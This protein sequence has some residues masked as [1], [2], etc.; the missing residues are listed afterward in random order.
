MLIIMSGL[1]GTGKSTIAR[2]LARRLNGMFLRADTIAQALISADVMKDDD[3]P[4]AYI[5]GYAVA[6]ENLRT[7]ATV[8][9][10]YV[11]GMELTRQAWRDVA[12]RTNV[13]FHAI[14]VICSDMA[15]HRR[16][17]ETRVSDIAGLVLPTWK[18]VVDRP[19]EKWDAGTITVDTSITGLE[20][21]I[22]GLLIQLSKRRADR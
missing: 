5:V 2:E 3:N 19:Y 20:D 1:P 8:V 15:E 12:A 13:P 22:A 14:E 10:D 6:E 9:A 21:A 16:R 17:V 7:G 18:Q 11:N 4:T